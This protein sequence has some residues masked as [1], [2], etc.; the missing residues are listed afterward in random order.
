[1]LDVP[2]YKNLKTDT[3][4]VQASYKMVLK[5]VFPE[6]DFSYSF[7]DKKTYHKKDKWT[8]NAGGLLYL[9]SLGFE[10]KNIEKFDYKQ[11]VQFGVRYLRHI[12]NEEVFKVQETYS[13]FNQEIRLAKKLLDNKSIKTLNRTTSLNEMEK[14][15]SAGYILLV[16]VNSAVFQRRKFYTSHKILITDITEKSIKFH[17]PGLPPLRNR[18][19]LKKTFMKAMGEYPGLVALKHPKM[20]H[21]D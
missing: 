9:A 3:H 11:F 2:F 4:C 15:F 16:P 12:W 10:V 14:L 13:D 1:M 5:Y 19:V 20:S 18:R 8:W 7:L 6:K 21:L 17:D